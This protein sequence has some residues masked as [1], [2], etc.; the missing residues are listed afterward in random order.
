[1]RFLCLPLLC[2]QALAYNPPADT[3]GPLTVSMQPAATGTYGAGGYADLS[4]PNVPFVV[5]VTLQNSSDREIS[6]TL[7][8]A[9]VDQWK[10]D[11]AGAVAFRL[12][13]RG[14]SRQEFTLT[15]GP[16]TLSA[17]YPIHA[18]AEFEYQGQK[19]VAH[20]V[21]IV[22][23][24]IPDVARPRLPVEWKP[25]PVP[26]PGMLGLWRIPVRRERTEMVR[27]GA[28]AGQVGREVFD[29][30]TVILYGPL[31]RSDRGDLATREG[32][33]HVLGRMGGLFAGHHV[34]TPAGEPE[35][36][37]GRVAVLAL[38]AVTGVPQVIGDFLRS[39]GIANVNS[40]G[41]RIDFRGVV[42]QR[43]GHAAVH[44]T[45]VLDVEEGEPG[46]EEDSGDQE[47]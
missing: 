19:L 1:M 6:G 5:P 37:D 25:V 38:F 33:C 43:S 9:V 40:A 27:L 21:M 12:G 2:F 13:P 39:E 42:E 16:G 3:A 15:F 20:P 32:D 26:N 41:P 34:D 24:R 30:G 45:F 23:P 44:D 10:V 18:Y 11:P 29:A 35:A 22:Q 14:R 4:R 36:A 7:R 47:P 31:G 8:L 17:H 46:H 28:D